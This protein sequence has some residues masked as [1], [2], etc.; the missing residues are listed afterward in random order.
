MPETYVEEKDKK[1]FIT[2]MQQLYTAIGEKELTD[3]QIEQEVR[4]EERNS[5]HIEAVELMKS[6]SVYDA[7][8]EK[9]PISSEATDRLNRVYKYML[10]PGDDEHNR[11]LQKKAA[12]EE[13]CKEIIISAMKMIC[14]EKDRTIFQ[15]NDI[16][17]GLQNFKKN[18]ALSAIA[19]S[20]SSIIRNGKV[21][22]KDSGDVATVLDN[23]KLFEGA[24][25]NLT[26]VK[27]MASPLYACGF[28]KYINN[29]FKVT[30][31]LVQKTYVDTN[32]KR[33]NELTGKGFDESELRS[34][35]LAARDLGQ[36]T[37]SGLLKNEANLQNVNN[38]S[39]TNDKLSPQEIV[40]YHGQGFKNLCRDMFEQIDENDRWYTRSSDEFAKIKASLKK[41]SSGSRIPSPEEYKNAM[42]QI[43]GLGRKYLEKKDAKREGM[44]AYE[45]AR[46]KA[47]LEATKEA[48]KALDIWNKEHER[49]VEARRTSMTSNMDVADRLPRVA[50]KDTYKLMSE[51]SQNAI[52]QDSK[53][54]SKKLKGTKMADVRTVI[55]A[56]R[57]DAY[58][59]ID[60]LR[61]NGAE[62]ELHANKGKKLIAKG[63]VIQF[64][65]AGS[66]F[67]EFRADHKEFH[68][69]S[70]FQRIG[71][72]GEKIALKFSDSEKKAK[73]DA[74]YGTPQKDPLKPSSEEPLKHFRKKEIVDEATHKTI[75]RYNVAGPISAIGRNTGEYSIRNNRLRAFEVFKNE[76]EAKFKAMGSKPE[77]AGPINLMIRGHSRGGVTAIESAMMVKAWL[78]ENYSSYENLVKFNITLHD[79]VPGFG[80][81]DNHALA[82][83]TD[84]TIR[85]QDG[86]KMMGL[87]KSADT[88]VI[89]SMHTD[90][91]DFFK[92]MEIKGANRVFMMADV[93]TAGTSGVDKTQDDKK[94]FRQG[95]LDAHTG[96]YYR[97]QSFSDMREGVYFID[98]SFNAIRSN[99]AKEALSIYN[100]VIN[101]SSWRQW[102]RH[103]VLRKVGE[104]WF[105][106]YPARKESKLNG[107]D[108]IRFE[109]HSNLGKF[110]EQVSKEG[111]DL[112]K[113]AN[114]DDA[115]QLT[116]EEHKKA[117]QTLGRRMMAEMAEYYDVNKMEK[118]LEALKTSVS[119]EK[120]SAGLAER[121]MISQNIKPNSSIKELK[122]FA[123]SLRTPGGRQ[124]VIRNFIDNVAEKEIAKSQ[125]TQTK[126]ITKEITKEKSP[127]QNGK[128]L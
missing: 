46:Y 127:V 107:V 2:K 55:E 48:T 13:G 22:T 110:M 96:D 66:G 34:I 117:I 1:Q 15:P 5:N 42:E 47:I 45:D 19:S 80:S 70:S 106:D 26:S 63:D 90:H 7:L 114:L 85:T 75:T 20:A 125:K 87:G 79:P 128:T 77:E 3:E 76:L 73:L 65:F 36:V 116:E 24:G 60:E 9:Y 49:A 99:D 86:V 21:T 17:Q 11:E 4:N 105:K 118:G 32:R 102:D 84:E 53:D 124:K 91:N 62:V 30:Q 50:S 38:A 23:T 122:D 82:D 29:T 57:K 109:P 12:S 121:L 18:I 58:A 100:D 14:S 108:T 88:T 72:H 112:E 111:P 78:H 67:N 95:I 64:N 52:N 71:P 115:A 56:K 27:Y 98:Q 97:G 39:N 104:E 103:N 94:W 92:P 54:H 6:L 35:N 44:S 10:I 113:I 61:K 25:N 28:D 37:Q 33:I 93:H 83:L 101:K 31:E 69:K 68:G 51:A 40:K 120:T 81:Y 123:T 16:N 43:A 59:K 119:D 89:Y 41:I 126:E 74:Y 8:L